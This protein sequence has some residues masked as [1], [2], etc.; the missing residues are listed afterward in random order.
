MFPFA[1]YEH[2]AVDL[3]TAIHKLKVPFTEGTV[4]NLVQA[5]S[6]NWYRPGPA[7][8]WQVAGCDGANDREAVATDTAGGTFNV[9]DVDA[10]TLAEEQYIGRFNILFIGLIS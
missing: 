9:E 7:A 10:G 5:S 6:L 1:Y 4:C 3:D 8:P 2:D